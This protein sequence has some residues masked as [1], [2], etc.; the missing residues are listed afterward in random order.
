MEN[1]E[2]LSFCFPEYPRYED[3]L[4]EED[5]ERFKDKEY[6]NFEP[7]LFALYRK[8]EALLLKSLKDD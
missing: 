4:S 5:K 2:K 6:M 3:L 8:L 7:L 1:R